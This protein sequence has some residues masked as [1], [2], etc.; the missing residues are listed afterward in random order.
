MTN[1]KNSSNTSTTH[2]AAENEQKIN[3][4]EDMSMSKTN[5]FT[6]AIAQEEATR[7]QQIAAEE[8]R[9]AAEA[10][11][12]RLKA[13][14]EA[15]EAE[16]KANEE[17]VKD[18]KPN[19]IVDT[20][21]DVK[22]HVV[23]TMND[24][25]GVAGNAWIDQI[26]EYHGH[27]CL[28]MGQTEEEVLVDRETIELAIARGDV[29]LPRVMM[30]LE[31]SG[32]YVMKEV[33]IPGAPP[34]LTK[35]HTEA[36]R[37]EDERKARIAAAKLTGRMSDVGVAEQ[38]V[39]A[40]LNATDEL[41]KNGTRLVVIDGKDARLFSGELVSSIRDIEAELPKEVANE[42][43]VSRADI[44]EEP[45]YDEDDLDDAYN[46]GYDDGYEDGYD[47]GYEDRDDEDDDDLP[48][49]FIRCIRMD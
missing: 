44:P 11:A 20:V 14:E 35:G 37:L 17:L 36:E 25:C 32:R 38:L 1:S 42:L 33:R 6:N 24:T 41:E 9:V 4:K 30:G 13:I 40:G 49:V 3:K 39:E 27:R 19:T 26:F 47:D 29:S 48:P 15:A 16:R 23:K 8:A 43:L 2:C 34:C 10:E 21:Q 7:A 18:I 12:A 28:A 22:D 45:E 5:N 46:D 31:V